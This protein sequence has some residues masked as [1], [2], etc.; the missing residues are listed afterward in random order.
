MSGRLR[1]AFASALLLLSA[2]VN[3][4]SA[5]YKGML[6]AQ[7]VSIEVPAHWAFLDT[8]TRRNLAARTD[9]ILEGA[10]S[11][12]THV[13]SLAV[14]A[15]PAPTGAIVRVSMI[16]DVELTQAELQQALR[17]QPEATMA[18]LRTVMNEELRVLDQQIR[19]EGVRILGDAKVSIVQLGG[20]TAIAS[21]YRR[22]SIG[23]DS[24]IFNVT[25]YH[26]PLGNE[27]ALI[28]LSY[29]ESSA[30]LYKPILE[31]VFKSISIR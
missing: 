6:V 18:E 15:T 30:L 21:N 22:T 10:V 29:R 9:A 12:P 16:E 20:K 13:A 8:D 1:R 7:R 24:T 14:N 28:T 26:V 2:G 27:K 4:G 19:K 23:S 5:N 31:H 3:A 25:Q 17:D 11:Y